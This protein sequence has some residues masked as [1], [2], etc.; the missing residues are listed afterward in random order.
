MGK[1]LFD[2]YSIL[3]MASGIIMYF[4]NIPFLWALVLHTI[5]EITENTKW[6][7]KIINTFFTKE[8]L[9]YFGW[10]GGKEFPDS[11]SNNIGD[12]IS[13]IFGYYLTNI[14]L[15]LNIKNF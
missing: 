5:F 10:P 12:T 7:M 4:W 1:I 2:K 9:I 6:G 14:I 8:K 11:I 3:H 15:F 13:M